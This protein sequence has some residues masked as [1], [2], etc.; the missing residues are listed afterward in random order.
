MEAL[1]FVLLWLALSIWATSIVSRHR[2]ADGGRIL[3]YLLIWLL[4]I[5]GAVFATLILAAKLKWKCTDSSD[6]MFRAVVEHYRST[7]GGLLRC[8]ATF[9]TLESLAGASSYD[10]LRQS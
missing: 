5:I 10:N 6:R 8:L 9:I 4:P 3:F 7:Q 2:S 1:I